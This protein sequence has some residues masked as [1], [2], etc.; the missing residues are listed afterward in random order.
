MPWRKAGSEDWWP[1]VVASASFIIEPDTE[2]PSISSINANISN[3][4]KVNVV[5]NEPVDGA[6]AQDVGN[7]AISHGIVIHGAVLGTHNKTVTLTTS[8]L[9]KGVTYTLTVDGVKD[10]WDNAISPKSVTT[11][12]L[13]DAWVDDFN[14]GDRDGWTA[15]EG[16]WTVIA[17]QLTNT[18]DEGRTSIW[19]GEPDWDDLT[20]EA[21]VTPG[22]ET[23]AWLIF[24]AQDAYNYYLFTL[25]GTGSGELYALVDG[26]YSKIAD[27]SGANFVTG[28][29]YRIR[30]ELEGSSIKVYDGD[31]KIVDA[32]DNRYS[33]GYLGFG[34]NL[35]T[36]TF[37]NAMVTLNRGAA[38]VR[39]AHSIPGSDK[40]QVRMIPNRMQGLVYVQA[41]AGLRSPIQLQIVNS[42]GQVVRRMQWDAPTQPKC[43][44]SRRMVGS[45]LYFVQVRTGRVEKTGRI[46][47]VR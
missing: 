26:N 9:S 41:P 32:T 10:V 25:Q 47:F 24:R 15:G 3:V 22:S 31:T 5:F 19:A 13:T 28:Q 27:G 7:Y 12:E 40:L 42:A 34:S 18:S 43:W 44:D 33:S 39:D 38:I 21:D 46:V 2:P 23:D 11:F 6:T 17:G 4:A 37:D 30:V 45:G 29:T 14:D 8:T 20:F 36:A 35:A 16:S 1:S